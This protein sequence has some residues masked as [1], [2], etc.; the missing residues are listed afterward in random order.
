MNQFPLFES[1]QTTIPPQNFS[2]QI[3]SIHKTSDSR[4]VTKN[5]LSFINHSI[6]Q[7]HQSP[8]SLQHSISFFVVVLCCCYCRCS[9]SNYVISQFLGAFFKSAFILVCNCWSVTIWKSQ[10]PAWLLV[11]VMV[12]HLD[13]TPTI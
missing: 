4:K 5:A 13:E 6:P 7:S 8:F 3:M 11:Q 1:C 12:S 10:I 9:K 2:P